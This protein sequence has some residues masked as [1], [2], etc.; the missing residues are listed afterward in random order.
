MLADRVIKENS[1]GLYTDP[2]CHE[3]M[4]YRTTGDVLWIK[5][6]VEELEEGDEDVN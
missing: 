4:R 5:H 6:Q 2:P 1:K 3:S